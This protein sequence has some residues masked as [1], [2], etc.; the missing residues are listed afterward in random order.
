MKK[1][2]LHRDYYVIC[3]SIILSSF[4]RVSLLFIFLLSLEV[5]PFSIVPNNNTNITYTYYELHIS[6][7]SHV[8]VRLFL[9]C[10]EHYDL[11][12]NKSININSSVAVVIKRRNL[13]RI[14]V[15]VSE[16]MCIKKIQKLN[17]K[18]INNFLW[19]INA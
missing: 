3:S 13:S 11:C 16:W 19:M 7:S 8:I 5:S 1:Y 10:V 14:C 6:L 2:V 4:S 12:C 9:F 17:E 18:K 15:W